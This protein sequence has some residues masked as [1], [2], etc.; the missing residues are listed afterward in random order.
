MP[1][2]HILLRSCSSP[3]EMERVLR[4][5]R[6]GDGIVLAQDA[7]YALRSTP[8]EISADASRRSLKFYAL[9][10]DMEARSVRPITGVRAIDYNDL[11]ELLGEY[12]RTYS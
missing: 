10:P 9:K 3:G 5:A 11:I 2:L 8:K 7:V 1:T 12:D 6:P 4:L